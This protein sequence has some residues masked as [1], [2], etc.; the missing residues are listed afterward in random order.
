M[1]LLFGYRYHCRSPGMGSPDCLQLGRGSSGFLF[2]RSLDSS[3]GVRDKRMSTG[4]AWTWQYRWVHSV[5]ACIRYWGYQSCCGSWCQCNVFLALVASPSH[6]KRRNVI[7]VFSYR[8]LDYKLRA[9]AIIIFM[10][11]I[12]TVLLKS[13]CT[14]F[15][16]TQVFRYCF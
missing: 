8:I 5:G 6:R 3:V 13:C 14:S 16:C 4:N 9:R 1:R 15:F 7:C 12:S 11:H 2:S 10:Y